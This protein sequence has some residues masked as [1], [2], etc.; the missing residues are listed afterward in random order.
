MRMNDNTKMVLTR[1]RALHDIIEKHPYLS[2]LQTTDFH[3]Y[4]NY[5]IKNAHLLDIDP[6]SKDLDSNNTQEY[7]CKIDTKKETV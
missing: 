5:V 3:R 7:T 1:I 2:R 6:W 4:L